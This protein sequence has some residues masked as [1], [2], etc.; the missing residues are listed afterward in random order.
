MVPRLVI[1]HIPLEFCNKLLSVLSY[2]KEIQKCRNANVEK[3]YGYVSAVPQECFEMQHVEQLSQTFTILWRIA[4]EG[5]YAK[6][7]IQ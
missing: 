6:Q 1:S 3:L 2:R 4:D 5:C 7:T